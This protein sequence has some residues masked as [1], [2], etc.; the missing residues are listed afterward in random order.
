MTE[1][2]CTFCVLAA[3]Q[4]GR[5]A[6]AAVSAAMRRG[7]EAL[8]GRAWGVAARQPDAG[9]LARSH[10]T[11][12]LVP[13]GTVEAFQ[14]GIDKNTREPDQTAGKGEKQRENGHGGNSFGVKM[15]DSQIC[16]NGAILTNTYRIAARSM[17]HGSILI[18]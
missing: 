14:Y 5:Y 11:E 8:D 16:R 6:K 2:F 4:P 13:L 17:L 10:V 3:R 18:P 9:E 12:S 7:G 1:L 15:S